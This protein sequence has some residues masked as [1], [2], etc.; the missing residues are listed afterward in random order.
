[1]GMTRDDIKRKANPTAQKYE[2]LANEEDLLLSPA[3]KQTDWSWKK[4]T[5]AELENELNGYNTDNDN[6]LSSTHEKKPSRN[7]Q[8]TKFSELLADINAVKQRLS[9]R[10]LER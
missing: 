7:F 4:K 5:A 3:P 1:M 2:M 10:D 6:N 9:E 8:E